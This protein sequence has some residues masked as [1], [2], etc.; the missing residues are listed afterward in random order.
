MTELLINSEKDVDEILRAIQS[1][2]VQGCLNLDQTLGELMAKNDRMASDQCV[3]EEDLISMAGRMIQALCLH[4]SMT[5]GW[6]AYHFKSLLVSKHKAYGPGCITKWG[7]LG[8][9]IRI[10]SKLNRARNLINSQTVD[11]GDE[12]LGDTLTDIVGYCVL[13]ILHAN[14]VLQ[15]A[16]YEDSISVDRRVYF[17]DSAFDTPA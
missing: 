15:V 1:K 2:T 10:D 7:L 8:I 4:D 9:I 14:A 3:T 6:D 13:G 5:G 16:N 11:P 17:G 12:A